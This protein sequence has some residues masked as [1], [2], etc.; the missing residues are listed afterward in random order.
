M[1][2][3]LLILVARAA[4]VVPADDGASVRAVRWARTFHL[5]KPEEDRMTAERRATTDILLLELEVDP[6]L[7]VP[8]QTSVPVLYVG[9]TPAR[10]LNWDPTGG[11][12]VAFVAGTP[13][14]S[15]TPVY[16]GST[17]LPERVDAA[18][19][20]AELSAAVAVGVR[21]L[22]QSMVEAAFVA[23][24]GPLDVED[25]RA[26]YAAAADR[27]ATCSPTEVERARNLR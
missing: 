9:T 10:P 23:G 4:D 6:A 22:P 15:T 1:P 13:D 14:L 27:I 24:G 18:R 19:G 5:T 26:V 20:A 21:P 25:I 8:A 12:L 17:E 3:L 7:V 16:F 11:C 2:L